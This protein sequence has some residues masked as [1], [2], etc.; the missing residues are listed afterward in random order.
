MT[1][2]RITGGDALDSQL[3]WNLHLL[4]FSY[5]MHQV[6]FYIQT[7]HFVAL[8]QLVFAMRLNRIIISELGKIC[9]HHHTLHKKDMRLPPFSLFYLAR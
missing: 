9:A 3:V 4:L 8:I 7:A 1:L 2:N 6:G 5:V